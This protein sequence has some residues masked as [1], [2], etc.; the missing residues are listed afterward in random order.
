VGSDQ[1]ESDIRRGGDAG[2]GRKLA[3]IF[4]RLLWEFSGPIVGWGDGL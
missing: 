2:G 3:K 1:R 4:Y